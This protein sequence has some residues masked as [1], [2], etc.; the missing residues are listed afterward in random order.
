MLDRKMRVVIAEDEYLILQDIENMVRNAGYELVGSAANGKQA[1]DLISKYQPDV[2]IL[3]IQMPVMDGLEA[4]RQILDQFQIPVVI[5]T[6]YESSDFLLAAKEAGV[7]AYLVKP[8]EANALQRAVTLAVARHDD[9]MELKRLN[10]ELT[11][12][13]AKL[14][15]AQQEVTELREFFPICCHCKRVRDDQGYWQQVEE[16]IRTHFGTMA[17]HGICPECSERVLKEFKSQIKNRPDQ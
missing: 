11:A 4:A 9:L 7:G 13:I 14:K 12:T 15:E 8:A 17:S 1:L 2:A 5:M 10:D 16:Y 6:A 3:D